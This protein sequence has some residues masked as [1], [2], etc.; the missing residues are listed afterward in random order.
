MWSKGDEATDPRPVPVMVGNR[1]SMLD[2]RQEWSRWCSPQTND[3]TNSKEDED[4]NKSSGSLRKSLA[5]DRSSRDTVKSFFGIPDNAVYNRC[6][7]D[8][9]YWT[10]AIEYHDSVKFGQILFPTNLATSVAKALRRKQTEEGNNRPICNKDVGFNLQQK[11]REFVPLVPG[12]VHSIQRLGI[13]KT[14][15]EWVQI[16]LSPSSE[17]LSLPVPAKALPDLEIRISFDETTKTTSIKDVALVNRQTK[18]MLQ[19]QNIV[20]LRFVREKRVYAKNDTI[21]PSILTFVQNSTLQ[22]WSTEPLKTPLGL[23]LSVP[24]L[25]IQ[26]HKDF[27][28]EKHDT[29]LVQYTSLGFELRSSLTMSYRALDSWPTLTYTTIEAGRIA[30]RREE[31]ELHDHEFTS[32]PPWPRDPDPS[33]SSTPHLSTMDTNKSSSDGFRTRTLFSKSAAVIDTIEKRTRGQ[34][35]RIRPDSNSSLE[36][37]VDRELWRRREVKKMVRKV[38]VPVRKKVYRVIKQ[39]AVRRKG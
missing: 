12:L 15:E 4:G 38:D 20:D 7:S 25:A 36:M 33:S 19:P 21:D 13:L 11:P 34:G 8:T 23:T 22:V 30:G 27:D 24:A 14:S 10:P 5:L 18:D 26:P 9:P 17:N 39:K 37:P 2:R 6:T 31:L 35:K 32:K 16:R 3:Q 29:L 1:L 28:P